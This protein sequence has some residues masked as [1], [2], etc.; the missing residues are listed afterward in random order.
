LIE[1]WDRDRQGSSSDTRII[2][3]HTND[4]VRELNEAAR[5]RMRV[6]GGLGDDVSIKAERGE[7]Q[8]ASGDRIMF[9]R[10]GRGLGVKNGT[11]GIVEQ[12]TPQA[13]AVR[14]DDGRAVKFDIKIMRMSVMV[15]PLRSIRRRA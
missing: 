8:F 2:L 3:T 7:R 12:V 14:T 15:M 11:L 13:M 1:R 4:E 10:N 9:L 6:A 5:G